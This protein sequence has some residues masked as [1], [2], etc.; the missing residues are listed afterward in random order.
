LIL[1]TV[2]VK[3]KIAV[4]EPISAPIHYSI[5]ETLRSLARA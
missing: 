2:P 1:N 5:E 4:Y 3:T